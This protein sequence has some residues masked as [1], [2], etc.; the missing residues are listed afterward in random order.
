[1][2]EIITNK[3]TGKTAAGDVTITDGST[4]MKLQEGIATARGVLD[5]NDNSTIDSHNIASFTDRAA[6]S[7]YGNYTNNM[8]SADHTV[9]GGI[10]PVAHGSMATNNYNRYVIVSSDTSARYSENGRDVGSNGTNTDRYQ[11]AVAYGDLA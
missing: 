8:S 4:T 2:S 5:F 9:I 1:M 6:G 7:L 11:A 10:S 3:L